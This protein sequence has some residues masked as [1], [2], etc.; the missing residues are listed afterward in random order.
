M[1]E[2]AIRLVVLAVAL[3][4][5]P[6]SASAKAK[7]DVDLA[8]VLAVDC[9]GSVDVTEYKL[10]VGGI[11]S[12]FRDPEIIAAIG[13]WAPGGLAVSVVQW[14]DET[15]QIV[16]VDWTKISDDASADALAAQIEASS[17]KCVGGTAIGDMLRFAIGY[18]ENGPFEAARRIIDVSG[19][20]RSS[21]GPTPDR[22]R[23]TATAA[24]IVINGLAILNE[25]PTLD[26]YYAD[27]V[28]GGSEAFV[29]A[30]RDYEDFARA[31][32]M[33]LLQEIRGVP[34]G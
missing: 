34:L 19:D 8:F 4:L 33:K 27:H 32:R 29:I 10:Q 2:C 7:L 14:S 1:R 16:A 17:C 6:S 21:A 3:A 25:D 20:G 31:M 12:A 28:I 23:D 15:W 11:A 5:S 22:F 26:Q 9:S 24:G 13:R 30:A 18:L